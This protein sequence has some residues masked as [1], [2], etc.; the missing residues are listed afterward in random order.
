MVLV[1]ISLSWDRMPVALE[2]GWS[3]IHLWALVAMEV[4]VVMMRVEVEG[5][6]VNLPVVELVA[7]VQGEEVQVVVE[8]LREAEEEYAIKA[9]RVLHLLQA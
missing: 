6:G 8:E 9:A 3:A 4:D 7:L 2:E 5:E 1:V